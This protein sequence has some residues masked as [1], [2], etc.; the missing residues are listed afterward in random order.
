MEWNERGIRFAKLIQTK[1]KAGQD[2][3]NYPPKFDDQLDWL[4]MIVNSQDAKPTQGCYDLYRDLKA[5]SDGYQKELQNILSVDL[6]AF[7]DQ[8]L[9]DGVGGVVIEGLE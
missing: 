2:P 4:Y 5:E 7:N 8:V 1:N 9:K 6:K 3:I